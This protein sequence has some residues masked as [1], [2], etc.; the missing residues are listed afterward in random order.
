MLVWRFIWH[1]T[2]ESSAG[3]VDFLRPQTWNSNPTGVINWLLFVKRSRKM[4]S[5]GQI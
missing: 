3:M 4:L 5:G 2:W 1:T